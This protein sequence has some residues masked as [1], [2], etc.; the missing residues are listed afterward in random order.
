MARRKLSKRQKTQI[1]E[2]QKK[3]DNN[4]VSSPD[5]AE[6]QLAPT[7]SGRV[8]AQYGKNL[9]IED[10]QNNFVLCY[11]RQNLGEIVCGDQINWQESEPGKGVVTGLLPRKNIL[12]R[13]GYGGKIK[14]LAANITQMIIVLAPRPEPTGY[15]L[16]QYLVAAEHIDVAVTI[17]LNKSDLLDQDQHQK[18]TAQFQAYRDIGYSVVQSSTKTADGLSDLKHALE[19][20]TS[21]LVGQS[22]VGKSS[23]IKELF[24]SQDIRVNS[25]SEATGLGKHTTSTTTLYT[26]P[27]GGDVIDSPGVR[28]F[29][30]PALDQRGLELG[31]REFHP[32]LG[33][34]RFSDCHHADEPGCALK[35]AVKDALIDK[36]RFDSFLNMLLHLPETH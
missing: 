10:K 4:L 32:Y 31:F 15:L 28:S 7:Q 13:P 27:D 26:L 9:L 16:D 14:A 33:H 5:L 35:D 8:I 20:Q 18:F 1:T 29:R 6:A 24:P 30:L 2:N 25:I 12:S 36:N 3:R 21:I 22:G 34:C 11:P 19:H 23:L 17:L